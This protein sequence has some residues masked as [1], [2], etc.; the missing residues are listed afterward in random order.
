MAS[1]E[2][3]RGNESSAASIKIDN[4]ERK[5][6]PISFGFSKTL[7]KAKSE[8]PEERDYLIEVDE[9]ELKRYANATS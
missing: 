5:Q 3:H 7:A 1:P 8:A 4:G 9:K 2:R 6:G